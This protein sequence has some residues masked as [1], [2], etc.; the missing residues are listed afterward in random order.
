MCDRAFQ[1]DYLDFTFDYPSAIE[2][3]QV[4]R[5]VGCLSKRIF[6]G[7]FIQTCV[8]KKKNY[9]VDRRFI[10]YLYEENS[11]TEFSKNFTK[12]RSENNFL[13]HQNNHVHLSV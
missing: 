6:R 10:V 4:H 5:N 2:N 9:V 8:S 1:C 3:F 13:D 11:F 12:C 7:L